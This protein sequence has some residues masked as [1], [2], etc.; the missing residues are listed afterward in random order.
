MI[1]RRRLLTASPALAAVWAARARAAAAPLE[2][3]TMTGHISRNGSRPSVKGPAECFTG[4]VRVDPLFQVPAPGKVSGGLVTFEPGAC[5]N[6]HT[7][8]C[9]QILMVVSGFGWTQCW[10]E[11][12]QDIGPGDV[13][14][15]PPGH[16]HWHGATDTTGM[17]HIAVQEHLGDGKVVEWLEPVT[18][19]QYLQKE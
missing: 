18:D 5:S 19:Q 13:I 8:P 3:T 12:R 4:S 10:G 1:T 9:G 16:K 2:R 6:W 11:A 17:S 7:H 14:W 15:C